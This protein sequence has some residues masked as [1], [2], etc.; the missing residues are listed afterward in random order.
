MAGEPI[1]ITI[2]ASP[3]YALSPNARTHHMAKYHASEQ[4]KVD[5]YWV[6]QEA[7]TLTGPVTLDWIIRLPKRRY[8]MDWDNAIATL[9]PAMDGLVMAGVIEDDNTTIVTR[10]GLT[11]IGWAKHKIDGGELVVTITPIVIERAESRKDQA[12]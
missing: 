8:A 7:D 1:T 6:A 9:K 12:A 4:L 5:T 3:A 11:Q 2:P 10:I